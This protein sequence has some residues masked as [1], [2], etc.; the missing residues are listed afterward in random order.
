VLLT[1]HHEWIVEKTRSLAQDLHLPLVSL[2]H[3]KEESVVV[4]WEDYQQALLLLPYHYTHSSSPVDAQ[5]SVSWNDWKEQDDEGEWKEQ[6]Y[7]VCLQSLTP[8]DRKKLRKIA[9]RRR[10]QQQQQQQQQASDTTTTTTTTIMLPSFAMKPTFVDFCRAPIRPGKDL[11]LQAAALRPGWRVYDLTA[12]LAQDSLLLAYASATAQVTMVERDPIVYTLLKD[13]MRRLQVVAASSSSSSSANTN[14]ENGNSLMSRQRT[15]AQRLLPML[16]L[17]HGDGTDMARRQATQKA[18]DSNNNNNTL[19]V[20]LPHVVYLD[21][22]FPPRGKKSASVKKNMQVLHQLF[23]LDY[24]Q[25]ANELL[26][27]ENRLAQ[28]SN[29]LQA[30]LQLA[31]VRVVCKRPIHAPPLGSRAN[32]N[33]KKK[34]KEEEEEE[35]EDTDDDVRVVQPSYAVSGSVNRWDVYLIAKQK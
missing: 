18:H 7:A 29:L 34:K 25:A 13:A 35:E 28:E 20:S 4:E 26:E 17:I 11:L 21:P 10:Q 9:Q 31:Q 24:S 27:E 8:A 3:T 6:N 14:V 22:M 12:G 23:L 30:A 15:T 19:L 2:L 33:N 1:T 32:S 5:L 16:Q